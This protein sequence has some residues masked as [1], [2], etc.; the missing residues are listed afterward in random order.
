MTF[1]AS[2]PAD[3]GDLLEDLP[4]TVTPVV[5]DES[6]FK[7]S[8]EDEKP[9]VE[10]TGDEKPVV[11]EADEKPAVEDEPARD[12][13][14]RFIPKQRFDEAV[15]KERD[16][17]EAAER[18]A[19]D[20]ER[21]LNEREQA[22]IKTQEVEE[23]E[24]KISELEETYTQYLLDGEKE[25]ARDTMKEIRLAERQIA[26][27]DTQAE[28]TKAT[29]QALEGERFNLAV[30]TLEAEYPEL[31]TE[32]ENYD[33]ELVEMILDK[34]RR[35][36]GTGAA[37]SKAIVEATSFVMKRFAKPEAAAEETKP[38]G[39]GKKPDDRKA[40]QVSKNVDTARRQPPSMKE[41]GLD[42]D[43]L[44]EKGMPDINQM[45]LEE[46]NAL[47]AATKSRMRGDL[48]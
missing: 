30:A 14:G 1:E 17:R 45:T 20:L 4:E 6:P 18:R 39:L 9:V 10:D 33:P 23:I 15:G 27:M 5:E 13:K 21:R 38:E 28:S 46:F 47:P 8:V 34:Q 43:K 25:K 19:Q 2:S 22:Q 44:G 29:N 16:A 31:N 24:S 11:E 36:V 12:E 41:V 32:S 3:R 40:A 42:S 35:L 26:R 37:P 48:V 7:P